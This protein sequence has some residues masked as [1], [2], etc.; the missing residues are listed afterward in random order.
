MEP[1]KHFKICLELV[2]LDFGGDW[3]DQSPLMEFA[4]NSC[5]SGIQM[6]PF[7]SLCGRS[8]SPICWEEVREWWLLGL[9]CVHTSTDNIKT[10]RDGLKTVQSRQKSYTYKHWGELEFEKGD[11]FFL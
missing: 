5:H 2:R 1:I 6:A 7:E 4:Y 11:F 9:E 10:T 8:C 3:D